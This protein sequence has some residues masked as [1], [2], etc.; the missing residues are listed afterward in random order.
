MTRRRRKT[1]R[2]PSVSSR[3]VFERFGVQIPAIR[4]QPPITRFYALTCL[5]GVRFH[6]RERAGGKTEILPI[7]SAWTTAMTREQ[8]DREEGEVRPWV[9]L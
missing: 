7:R 9:D 3:D 5:D 2:D 8:D 6:R 1:P 4:A